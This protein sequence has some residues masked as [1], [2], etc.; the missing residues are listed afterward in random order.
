LVHK[1]CVPNILHAQNY[2]VFPKS[3]NLASIFESTFS[4]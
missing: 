1:N 4:S 2:R 3:K